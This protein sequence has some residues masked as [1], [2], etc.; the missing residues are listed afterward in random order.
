MR[1]IY[2]AFVMHSECFFFVGG[3]VCVLTFLRAA[4]VDV[5]LAICMTPSLEKKLELTISFSV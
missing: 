4:V 2:S 5:S 1:V 3:C